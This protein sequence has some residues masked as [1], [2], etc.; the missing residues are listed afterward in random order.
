MAASLL[1]SN[2]VSESC[3]V[4]GSAALDVDCRSGA[5][6]ASFCPRAPTLAPDGN[7]IGPGAPNVDV[8]FTTSISAATVAIAAKR[9]DREQPTLNV[10]VVWRQQQ[11]P[12]FLFMDAS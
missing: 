10:F 6:S 12:D 7:A 1:A 8:V 11:F 5:R 9:A 3:G 2:V 4:S